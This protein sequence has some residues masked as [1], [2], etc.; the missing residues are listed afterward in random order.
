MPNAKQLGSVKDSMISY[1]N[2]Q[3]KEHYSKYKSN[4]SSFQK[5]NERQDRREA[6]R[7]LSHYS[8]NKKAADTWK[9]V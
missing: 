6:Y 5:T 7:Q 3:A 8:D 2:D 9:R 4:M 1:H